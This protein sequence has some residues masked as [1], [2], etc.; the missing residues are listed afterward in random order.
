MTTQRTPLRRLAA[1]VGA[2]ALVSMTAVAFASTASAAEPPGDGPDFGS[3][4]IHKR[5]GAQGDAGNG[6]V[7][8]PA[9]GIPLGGIT[10]N[11]QRV[12]ISNAAFT[13]V[14]IDLGTSAGWEAV[15]GTPPQGADPGAP[16]ATPTAAGQ[17]CNAGP[18]TTT[19][20][21]DN[22]SGITTASGLPLG[23]YY[24]TEN[25]SA[26]VT[27]LAVPFYV[28]IPFSSKT[29]DVSTWLYDLN[30]YPKNEIAGE[31]SK[32]LDEVDGVVVG[33]GEDGAVAS[34]T[35]TSP[36]LG[37][38]GL[39]ANS[40]EVEV[41]DRLGACL[42]YVAG[43]GQLTV[44]VPG[45]ADASSAII[46]TF[47]EGTNNATFSHTFPTAGYPAGTT[48]VITYDTT[49]TCVDDNDGSTWNDSDW[50]QDVSWWGELEVTKQDATNEDLL[51]G[52]EFAVYAGA[53][54][55]TEAELTSPVATGTTVNGIWT[56]P[57]LYVGKGDPAPVSAEYCLV[58]TEAPLGYV[59]PLWPS[60]A[61]TLSIVPGKVAET[62][63]EGGIKV[64]GNYTVVDN[65]PIPGPVLP[66][67]GAEGTML[68]TLAGLALVAVAGGGFLVR[69]AHASH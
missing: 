11:V 38:T 21:T 61:Q 35:L 46:P 37:S 57:G 20:A 59:Q 4:I 25:A 9:P 52:A 17:L 66:L 2:L 39:S 58:E 47:A 48:F 45:S 53:C 32:T 40:T 62:E 30:V 44:K 36:V 63:V 7:K 51:N 8:D 26:P 34:W 22:T 54:P 56:S 31:P 3:L 23:L 18:A 19:A 15:G 50:G 28:T 13:C 43:S 55:A 5:V 1:G 16:V 41:T 6:T 64:T 60:K 49:V 12:G 29:G 27:A 67:T 65:T 10:F 42:A 14:P 69:R 68:F 24:V 33:E